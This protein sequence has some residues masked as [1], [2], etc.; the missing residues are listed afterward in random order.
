MKVYEL[1][2]KLA[3]FPS[4]AEVKCSASLTI[5][6]LE[7]YDKCGED[8][9]GDDLYSF[10]KDLNFVDNDNDRVYLEF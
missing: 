7:N 4:G 3:E 5:P 1:M 10:Y 9:Y 8:E 6:E 2:S